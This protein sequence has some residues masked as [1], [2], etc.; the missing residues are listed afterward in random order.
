MSFD[1]KHFWQVLFF[2]VLPFSLLFPILLINKI[3]WKWFLG[4]LGFICLLSCSPSLSHLSFPTTIHQIPLLCW[5]LPWNS[6][7][8][9]LHTWFFSSLGFSCVWPRRHNMKWN[10]ERG[11][12]LFSLHFARTH[13]LLCPGLVSFCVQ[14]WLGPSSSDSGLMG[15][16]LYNF[17]PF[18]LG[19]III[20][21][22]C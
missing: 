9:R 14:Q 8:Y 7:F 12:K 6:D 10:G 13:V 15:C 16:R 18:D 22:C 21:H 20:S 2:N 11:V 5:S 19:L 1:S 17:L 4:V 3:S